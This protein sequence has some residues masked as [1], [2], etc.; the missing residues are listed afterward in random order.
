MKKMEGYDFTAQ[1][2]QGRQTAPIQDINEKH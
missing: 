2:H 1:K